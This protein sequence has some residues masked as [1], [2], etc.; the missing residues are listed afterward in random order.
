[1]KSSIQWMVAF[2]AFCSPGVLQ[3]ELIDQIP[4]PFVREFYS[5][6]PGDPPHSVGL[7]QYDTATLAP[8][9]L[10]NFATIFDN[11]TFSNSGTVDSFSWI[12]AYGK[13]NVTGATFEV[14]FYAD[15]GGE[16]DLTTKQG[17]SV[18]IANETP[19]VGEPRFYTYNTALTPFAVTA[20]NQY[21]ASIV[22]QYNS[23]PQGD[24]LWGVAFSAIGDGGSFQDYGDFAITRYPDAI[25]YA[26]R[27]STVPEPTS[28]VY[29]CSLFGV[30]CF[31]RRRRS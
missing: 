21:W 27:I 14:A 7:S 23:G 29:L 13:D 24:D 22:S 18:G 26:I 31:R 1:M 16:P 2:V 25:D 6:A 10:H 11:F 3:A 17:Y 30:A 9:Q 19:I 12:G 20:G 8:G 5:A 15:N 4:G 28:M